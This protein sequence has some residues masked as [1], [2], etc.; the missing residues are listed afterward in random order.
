[1][2][3]SGGVVAFPTE[4]VYGLGANALDAAAV[5][6]VFAAK[7]RPA[8]NPVI[9]HVAD[10]EQLGEVVAEW[11]EEARRLSARFWPGPLSLVLAR[12]PRIPAIVTAGG[13]TVAVRM[14]AHPVAERMIR[15]A[16]CPVAAPSANRS[17]RI[18]PTS[19]RH[20]LRMLDGRIDLVLDAGSTPGG[21]ESTVLDLTAEPPVVLRPGLIGRDELS[22][23]LN[24][25][26][27]I[28]EPDSSVNIASGL[29]V[30]P[31]QESPAAARS[32]GLQARHYAPQ[33]PVECCRQG[34]RQ[35]VQEL[36]AAG[37]RVGW[38]HWQGERQLDDPH[39]EHIAMP[40]DA[41]EYAVRL[42]AALHRL[43]EA[44]VEQ[45]I[46]DFPPNEETWLA[47]RDRLRRA[48]R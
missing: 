45:I 17:A 4:T 29:P 16:G 40:R 11:P 25:P 41:G 39:V 14:P 1:M 30:P 18:S 6:R 32:P 13:P 36:A 15:A 12:H 27:A 38:L 48:S 44:G 22:A 20:V 35:R 24:R 19:A 28:G 8:T 23:V 42:Y 3:R 21:I 26:V 5:E 31:D 43:E 46:V 7:G 2:L 33:A 34:S 37:K 47:I 9:V 10:I